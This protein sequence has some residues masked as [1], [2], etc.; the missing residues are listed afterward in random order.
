MLC[1]SF[2]DSVQELSNCSQECSTASA[3]CTGRGLGGLIVGLLVGVIVG[4]IGIIAYL[5]HNG[6]IF[7]CWCFNLY[8]LIHKMLLIPIFYFSLSFVQNYPEILVWNSMPIVS[9]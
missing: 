7:T 4:I 3:V 8:G 1:F 9:T 6:E 5:Q 2:L